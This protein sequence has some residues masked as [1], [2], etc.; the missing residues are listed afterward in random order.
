MLPSLSAPDP[1]QALADP[2]A[3][4]ARSAPPQIK[5]EVSNGIKRAPSPPPKSAAAA[6]PEP[7]CEARRGLQG[8]SV[9]QAKEAAD[10]PADKGA[11]YQPASRIDRTDPAAAIAPVLPRAGAARSAA[12]LTGPAAEQAR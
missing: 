8:P 1:E 7:S 2:C 3:P 5:V 6:V 12:P 9:E 11:I 4:R 10:P